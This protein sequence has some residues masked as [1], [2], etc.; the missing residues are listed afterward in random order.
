PLMNVSTNWPTARV[1]SSTPACSVSNLSSSSSYRFTISTRLVAN[2]CLTRSISAW[3]S[4]SHIHEN[5]YTTPELTTVV[6]NG[7][8]ETAEQIGT[9][10]RLQE[11][12]RPSRA[13]RYI[14]DRNP[15]A[16]ARTAAQQS[17]DRIVI[18]AADRP[19]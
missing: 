1:I 6:K 15:A 17:R 16:I 13:L 2:S 9:A 14:S 19:I 3:V 5:S 8:Y 7:I 11:A 10:Q 12:Q 4:C 18:T